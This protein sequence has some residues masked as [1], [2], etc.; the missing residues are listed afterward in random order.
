MLGDGT[1][2]TALPVDT[3]R[4]DCQ[5][6]TTAALERSKRAALD[7]L[8]VCKDEVDSPTG[9]IFSE[10]FNNMDRIKSLHFDTT[11]P[12]TLHNLS[13]PA[14]KLEM[15]KIFTAEQPTELGVLFGG[16]LPALRNLT[17]AG[18][19]SW[20]LGLFSKL[21]QLCLILPSSH[22]TVRISSLIDVMS[23]SPDI[24]QIR[25]SAFLSVID[26]SPP[27]SL[28]HLPNLQRFV[29]RNCDSSTV[30]SHTVIPATANVKIITDH[31]TMKNVLHIPSRDLHI[32]CS[33]PEDLSTT[34]FL[35][36]A[37]MLV[38][39]RDH[40]VGFGLGFY[41][42]R[43]SQ[44]SLRILDHSTSVDLFARRSIEALASRSH[45]FRNIKEL[46]FVLS[47]DIAVPWST[48]LRGFKQLE[49]LSMV[50]LHAPPILSALMVV[51]EDGHPICPSLNQLNIYNRDDDYQVALDRD[52]MVEFFAA[53][54]VLACAA[55]EVI[56]RRRGGQKIVWKCRGTDVR[57]EG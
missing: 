11:L 41:R 31:H 5:Q 48:L 27:S 38:I 16:K 39:Q 12:G 36:E 8:I 57:L 40:E 52:D 10:L 21:K 43:S 7:V 2:W 17:L 35:T 15:L 45:H 20:P 30:L 46:F 54:R 14:P 22:P 50:A 23:R 49:L 13:A 28:V 6:S 47:A 51:G 37:T 25:M 1:L 44:P 3:S 34:G 33:V 26:D 53:R 24:E 9:A 29:M 18:I 4:A 19:P 42:S 32:L 56:I 55:A